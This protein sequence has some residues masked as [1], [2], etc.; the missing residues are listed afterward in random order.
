MEYKD[1]IADF[2][3]DEK[4]ELFQGKVSNVHD[5]ITFQ[6]KSIENLRYAFED[7]IN[8]YIA[9]CKKYGNEPEK[10]SSDDYQADVRTPHAL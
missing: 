6:A 5:V 9:W 3:F 7:A 10:R 8:E 1:Y 4:L 2:I